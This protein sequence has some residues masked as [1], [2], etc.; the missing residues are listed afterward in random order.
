MSMLNH[1]VADIFFLTYFKYFISPIID[2]SP[3]AI[4]GKTVY[5]YTSKEVF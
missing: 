3:K 5:S 2:L 4:F 1:I